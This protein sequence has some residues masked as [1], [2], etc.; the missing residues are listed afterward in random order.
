MLELGRREFDEL[1]REICH[2]GA[3]VNE[4]ILMKDPIVVNNLFIGVCEKKKHAT[5]IIR[6]LLSEQIPI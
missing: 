1:I 5:L 2:F 3:K 4:F 6:P